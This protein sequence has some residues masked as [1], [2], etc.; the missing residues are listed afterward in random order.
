MRQTL[1]YTSDIYFYVYFTQ[2]K[3]VILVINSVFCIV[4]DFTMISLCRSY[5]YNLYMSDIYVNNA[6]DFMV[7]RLYKYF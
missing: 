1:F 4:L 6:R 5:K 2:I 7:Y 3:D